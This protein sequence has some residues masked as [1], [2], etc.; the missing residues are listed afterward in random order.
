MDDETTPD[1]RAVWLRSLGWHEGPSGRWS[2]QVAT[3][4]FGRY[5]PMSLD[6][7]YDVALRTCV[8][9]DRF[10]VEIRD[11]RVRLALP[12]REVAFEDIGRLGDTG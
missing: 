7:A 4:R 11:G 1:L 10:R 8:Y 12:W 2:G 6:H 5:E 9:G 3:T